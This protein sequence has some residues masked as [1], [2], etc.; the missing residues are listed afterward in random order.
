MWAHSPILLDAAT[1]T[2]YND[3]YTTRVFEMHHY[4]M[5]LKAG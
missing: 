4:T 5:P 3:V 1:T 2:F